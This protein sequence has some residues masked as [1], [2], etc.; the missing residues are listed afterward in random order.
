MTVRVVNELADSAREQLAELAEALQPYRLV[1]TPEEEA[2]WGEH[3]PLELPYNPQEYE[4]EFGGNWVPREPAG[5]A[6]YQNASDWTHS[7]P[8]QLTFNHRLQAL[9]PDE[10]DRILSTLR[11]WAVQP[12]PKVG[13]PPILTV[14]QGERRFTG[15]LESVAWRA[16]QTDAKGRIRV[17]HLNLLFVQNMVHFGL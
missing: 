8:D 6:P 1:I 10:N 15:H 5:A 3:G 13:R 14:T 12:S 2:D 16:I 9:E 11:A 17:L 7:S 4:G